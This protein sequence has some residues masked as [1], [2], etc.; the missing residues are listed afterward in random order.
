MHTSRQLLPPLEFDWT[1]FD[2]IL[3]GSP[4]DISI[5]LL[6]RMRS[7]GYVYEGIEPDISARPG[8]AA[9]AIWV[10]EAS[11]DEWLDAVSVARQTPE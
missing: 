2:E 10:T 8:A 1:G 6:K 7:V 9:S 3:A 4:S 11:R 5:L